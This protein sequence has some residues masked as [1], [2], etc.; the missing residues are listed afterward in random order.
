[1]SRSLKFVCLSDT[2]NHHNKIQDMPDGDVL[3]FAGDMSRRGEFYEIESFAKWLEK[4]PY[5]HKV[6]IA[7]N[8]DIGLAE[9]PEKLEDLF[10]SIEGC[11]YLN[12]ASATIEGI[13]IWGEP[14]TPS[15]GNWA[16]LIDRSFMYRE[17][18][19]K[20]PD[21]VDILLTHGP[22]HG[23][24]DLV[25]AA[26]STNYLERVGCTKLRKRIKELDNLKLVVC[27]HIHEGYGHYRY[28]GTDIFVVSVLDENYK[29]RNKP[30][31]YEI[32]VP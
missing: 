8:H 21:D 22:P 28:S 26:H 14:R 7:G 24:G 20:I 30:V 11:H 15:F 27:G 16:F 17:C 23:C 2:H 10:L 3:L 32:E 29:F 18:W 12:Q 9:Y 19:S 13:K 5:R 4:Q 31:V 6:V 25:V 1:M